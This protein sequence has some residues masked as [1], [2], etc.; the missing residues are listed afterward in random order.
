MYPAA[1]HGSPPPSLTIPSGLDRSLAGGGAP[2]VVTFA[3]DVP[4]APGATIT[5]L[6]AGG[7]QASGFGAAQ[8]GDTRRYRLSLPGLA[9]DFARTGF[10]GL[11]VWAQG[12]ELIAPQRRTAWSSQPMVVSAATRG[13]R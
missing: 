12:Q 10:I 1:T 11:A 6:T 5:A 9:L 8:G 13:R 2:L 4:S 7:D 3:G